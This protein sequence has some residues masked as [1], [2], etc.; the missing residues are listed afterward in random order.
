MCLATFL[1]QESPFTP[2][3]VMLAAAYQVRLAL[4][5]AHVDPRDLRMWHTNRRLRSTLGNVLDKFTLIIPQSDVVSHYLH[6][7]SPTPSPP[8]KATRKRAHGAQT[9]ALLT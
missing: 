8:Y 2:Q 3:L 9:A 4:I 5:N 7:Y 6:A 1:A